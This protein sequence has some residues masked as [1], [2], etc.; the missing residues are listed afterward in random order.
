MER[1]LLKTFRKN[2]AFQPSLLPREPFGLIASNT[3]I[4]RHDDPIA[5]FVPTEA[6]DPVGVLRGLVETVIRHEPD[7]A[8][9]SAIRGYEGVENS[10]VDR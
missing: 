10:R 7:V 4:S 2:K 5:G 6:S 3:M 1:H 9:G 8:R